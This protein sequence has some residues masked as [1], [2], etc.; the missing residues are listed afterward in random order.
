MRIALE[1]HSLMFMEAITFFKRT[2]DTS[3]GIIN[4]ELGLNDLVR[5]SIKSD[6]IKKILMHKFKSNRPQEYRS[7]GKFSVD[8]E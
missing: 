1:Q 4:T 5:T 6:Q 8:A 2:C 3:K 7:S